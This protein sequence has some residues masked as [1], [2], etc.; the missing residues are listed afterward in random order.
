MLDLSKVIL[1]TGSYSSVKSGKTVSDKDNNLLLQME[2]PWGCVF[3]DRMQLSISE[4]SLL[5]KKKIMTE[6]CMM[7]F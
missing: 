5:F 6:N 1:G 4:N 7:Q 2:S 3:Y